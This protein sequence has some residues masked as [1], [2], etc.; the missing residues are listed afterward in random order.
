M[1]TAFEYLIITLGGILY[2]LATVCL[3]LPN[4]FSFGGSTGVGLILSEFIPVLPSTI[5][6]ILNILLMV[7][8]FAILGRQFALRTFV[9]S[10][11]T[12][13]A[14]GLFGMIPAIGSYNTGMIA[15]DLLLAV[16]I[17]AAA[18]A[19]LFTVNASSGGTD[20]I[21]MIIYHKLPGMRVGTA[22]LCA[23]VVIVIA[24][25]FLLGWRSGIISIVGLII[26]CVLVEAL[27]KALK[28][29]LGRTDNKT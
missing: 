28:K 3:V 6:A 20:I 2:A 29:K 16:L 15:V 18:S 27:M 26:K 12:T 9:G 13:V 19:L 1:K 14:I 25:G 21:A 4:S 22:L 8:A 23:D 10:A 17:I 7:L 24:T 11:V 5:T